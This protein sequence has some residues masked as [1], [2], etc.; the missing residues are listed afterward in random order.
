M[1]GPCPA[2]L[3]HEHEI[4]I[5]MLPLAESAYSV[6]EALDL[7]PFHVC[8]KLG[9]RK[10]CFCGSLRRSQRAESRSRWL[11]AL[12]SWPFL[13][14]LASISRTAFRSSS[15]ANG[16]SKQQQLPRPTIAGRLFV[17]WSRCPPAPT[18]NVSHG[19][20]T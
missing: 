14:C 17:T 19:I 1:A 11:R 9:M 4:E 13:P 15:L 5:E 8:D 10:V 6:N 16:T 2:R 3:F 12:A 7:L 20:T 18:C